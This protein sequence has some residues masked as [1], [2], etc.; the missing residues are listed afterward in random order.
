MDGEREVAMKWPS[1][2]RRFT[3]LIGRAI[4]THP[5]LL[6]HILT[7]LA[8]HLSLSPPFIFH[9]I[10]PFSGTLRITEAHVCSHDPDHKAKFLRWIRLLPPGNTKSW[11]HY[12]RLDSSPRQRALWD[13]MWTC[14]IAVLWEAAGPQNPAVRSL[15]PRYQIYPC[16]PE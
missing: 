11:W 5:I 15:F 16:F 3:V 1:S 9:D 14:Y 4:W 12:V 10:L 8:R 7:N 6:L 13:V 2:R